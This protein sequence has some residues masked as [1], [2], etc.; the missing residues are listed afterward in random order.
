MSEEIIQQ[1]IPIKFEDYKTKIIEALQSKDKN[2]LGINED[3]QL[4]D[5]FFM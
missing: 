5:G 4:I 2:K 3:I 1:P